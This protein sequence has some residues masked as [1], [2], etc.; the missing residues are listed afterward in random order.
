MPLLWTEGSYGL[1]VIWPSSRPLRSRLTNEG[2]NTIGKPLP[3]GRSLRGVIC[4]RAFDI[5]LE[6]VPYGLRQREAIPGRDREESF[7]IRANEAL[8]DLL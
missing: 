6:A 5:R 7:A 4:R 3:C 2:L 1:K 8:G